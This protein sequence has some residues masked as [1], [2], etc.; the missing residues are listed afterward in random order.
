MSSPGASEPVTPASGHSAKKDIEPKCSGSGRVIAQCASVTC[1]GDLLTGGWVSSKPLS[2]FHRIVSIRIGN[3]FFPHFEECM[4]HFRVL[5]EQGGASTRYLEEPKR[6]GAATKG[7]NA[8]V[9]NCARGPQECEVV[10]PAYGRVATVR[11]EG[12]GIAKPSRRCCEPAGLPHNSPVEGWAHP[13]GICSQRCEQ[14]DRD[15]VRNMRGETVSPPNLL[16][17]GEP[18]G[19][20]ALHALTEPD[21]RLNICRFEQ[22]HEN[23]MPLAVARPKRTC[24]S[25]WVRDRPLRQRR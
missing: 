22:R 7:I 19:R 25:Q 16:W 4:D 14:L 24:E 15:V 12:M 9:N 1:E 17:G 23:P 5:N 20:I 2:L 8:S 6:T 11:I 18:S 3:D 21:P 10:D 13:L